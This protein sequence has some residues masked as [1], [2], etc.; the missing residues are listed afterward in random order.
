MAS[1]LAQ[2]SAKE[3]RRS[4]VTRGAHHFL[5]VLED[6][7]DMGVQMV[8]NMPTVSPSVRYRWSFCCQRYLIDYI[9]G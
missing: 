7:N 1:Y 9:Y 2:T 5:G 6:K 4:S 3:E 8:D